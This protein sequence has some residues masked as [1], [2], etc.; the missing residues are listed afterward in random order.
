MAQIAAAKAAKTLLSAC[1]SGQLDVQQVTSIF[2]QLADGSGIYEGK[3]NGIVGGFLPITGDV[4]VVFELEGTVFGA[5]LSLGGN[6]GSTLNAQ[7]LAFQNDVGGISFPAQFL[8]QGTFIGD[9]VLSISEAGHISISNSNSSK[10]TV[11]FEGDFAGSTITSTL[12]GSY[13]GIS[14]TGGATLQKK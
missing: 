3:Y 8:L 4:Q 1:T 10:G 12:G 11:N 7:P 5:T 9:V 14:F 2:S 6:L 13:S